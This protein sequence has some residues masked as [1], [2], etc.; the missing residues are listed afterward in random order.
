ME[1][2]MRVLAEELRFEEA[3]Q[4]RDQIKIMGEELLPDG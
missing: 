3:G 4:L 2:E 1:E